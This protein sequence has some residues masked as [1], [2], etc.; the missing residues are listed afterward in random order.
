MRPELTEG[1]AR[2]HDEGLWRCLFRILRVH[3]DEGHLTRDTA[4]LPFALGGLGLRSALR[5]RQSAYWAS[6]ADTLPM[7]RARHPA[8]AASFV[9]FLTAG[10]GPV[11]LM[12]A[13]V[14]RR[15]LFG[16]MGFAPPSWVDLANGARPSPEVEPDGW[17]TGWQHEASSR[18]ERRFREAEL[19]AR[20]NDTEKALLRSQSGP[21]A[22]AALAAVPT[23]FHTRLEPHLFRLLLLRRLRLPLPPSALVCRCGRFLDAFGHHRAACAQAGLLS[24][25]GFAVELAAAKICREAG[26]RVTTNVMVRDLDLATPQQALDGRRLEVVA[27]GLPLFGGVQLAIDTTLVSPVRAD[28]TARRGAAQHDGVARRTYPELVGPRSR[29]RLVVLA[30]EVGGRWSGETS[31]FLRLLAAAKARPEPPIL[32]KRAECAWRSRWAA[33]LSFAAARAFACSLLNI[34]GGSGVDGDVPLSHE[35]MHEW[36]HVSLGGPD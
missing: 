29:A 26:A 2:G 5:S 22:G 15:D 6:W 33:I 27:D 9:E 12:S 20:F 8:T 23:S 13:E 4:T 21:L 28:G 14:A 19:M 31:S 25:R 11:S 32:R 10:V 34:R 17:R 35:V 3:H 1:F 16:V 7:V 30:R 24:R 18:V 36:R